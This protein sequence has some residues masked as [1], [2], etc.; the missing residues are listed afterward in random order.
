MLTVS[1]QSF[2]DDQQNMQVFWVIVFYLILL[3][4]IAAVVLT[5]V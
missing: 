4:S 1:M 3:D 5:P 2:A